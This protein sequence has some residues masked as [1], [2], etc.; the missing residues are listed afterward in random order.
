MIIRIF[1]LGIATY[2]YSAINCNFF[3]D[4][5]LCPVLLLAQGYS[6]LERPKLKKVMNENFDYKNKILVGGLITIAIT[7]IVINILICLF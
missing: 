1:F 7:V 2:L 6:K 5:L 3:E 4:Y